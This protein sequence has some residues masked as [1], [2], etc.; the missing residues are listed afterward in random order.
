MQEQSSADV[1]PKVGFEGSFE[2]ILHTF[3]H[4]IN[5]EKIEY[6]PEPIPISLK[7]FEDDE[8]VYIVAGDHHSMLLT[9]RGKVYAWGLGNK[10]QLGVPRRKGLINNLLTKDGI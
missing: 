1:T 4:P 5:C 2:N 10:G 6:T 8:V 7:T 9:A 3:E